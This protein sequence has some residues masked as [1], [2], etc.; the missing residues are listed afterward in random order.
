MGRGLVPWL[1]AVKAT[2]M[3]LEKEAPMV[4]KKDSWLEFELGGKLALKLV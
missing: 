2:R 3:V 4:G 1:V